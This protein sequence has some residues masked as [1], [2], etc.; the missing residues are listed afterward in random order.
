M[1]WDHRKEMFLLFY[2]WLLTSDPGLAPSTAFTDDFQNLEN[3]INRFLPTLIPVQQ[4][5]ATT[6]D[7]KHA[8]LTNHTLAH[9][10]II[11]LYYPFG[12]EDP[13][14]YEK[15]L[16][17]AR[18][19]VSIIK[20]LSEVDFD[21]LDPIIGVRSFLGSPQ[22]IQL[23][24]LSLLALL[25]HRRRYFDPRTWWYWGIMASDEHRRYSRRNRYSIICLDQL[26]R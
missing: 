6:P 21:F 10:A 11:H 19:I 7:D 15:S 17:S 24:S 16:R 8:F 26:E 14:S 5:D 23:N 13:A 12:T 2:H 4:L 3:T 20:H 18:S 25:G 1:N 9:G 22:T